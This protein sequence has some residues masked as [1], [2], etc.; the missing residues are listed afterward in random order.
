MGL[1]CIW[2]LSNTITPFTGYLCYCQF[3]FHSRTFWTESKITSWSYSYSPSS[4]LLDQLILSV[5]WTSHAIDFSSTSLAIPYLLPLPISPFPLHLSVS[6]SLFYSFISKGG[7]GH[8][9]DLRPLFLMILFN[10]MALNSF[11]CW[12]VPQFFKLQSRSLSQIPEPYM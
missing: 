4:L 7:D 11:L 8:V 2:K 12:W 9:L 3:G 5:F 6:V 10:P 1:S